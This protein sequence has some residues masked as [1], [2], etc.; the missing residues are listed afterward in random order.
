[1]AANKAMDFRTL[2][3][4][5]LDHDGWEVAA[6]DDD[7]DW[8]VD[9]HWRIRSVRQANGLTLFVNFM[10]DPQYEEADKSSAVWSITASTC[11]PS[12]R[13]DTKSEVAAMV[14]KKG[15]LIP[16]LSGFVC[17]LNA[18]RDSRHRPQNVS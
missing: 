17:Q 2:L 8:W 3:R 15:R 11:L 6:I 4:D 16:N 13:T 5:R 14:L 7:T 10:V 9:Q 12:G 18:Y 1:M